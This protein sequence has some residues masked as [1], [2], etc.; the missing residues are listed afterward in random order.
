VRH[1]PLTVVAICLTPLMAAVASLVAAIWF[2]ERP[3]FDG[4]WF[5]AVALFFAAWNIH[6]SFGRYLLWK[7]RAA[8]DVP[9]QHV[10][11]L[12]AIGTLFVVFAILS[13][14]GALG[15]SLLALAAL[16]VDTGGTP[17]FVAAIVKS[18]VDD[19]L[20]RPPHV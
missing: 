9:Y 12:P 20:Q 19:R 8:A 14:F 5:V 15:T 16:V 1:V 6:C 4:W 18:R 17:W 10:S 11:G 13:G 7:W 2:V 3:A